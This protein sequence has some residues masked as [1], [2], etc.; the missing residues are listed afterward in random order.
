MLKLKKPRALHPRNRFSKLAK[1]KKDIS[2]VK[3]V[4]KKEREKLSEDP[5]TFFEQVVGFKPTVYQR[6]LAEKFMENQFT[7]MRWNRQSG[8]S[9]ISSALL[10]NYALTHPGAYIGIIAPGWRQSKLVIR[11]IRYFL[12][13]LPNEICPKPQ[14]TVLY[15]SNGSIIEAFP[16]NP[17][18]IRGPTLNLIYW[19]EANHTPN[20]WDM[21]TAILFTISATKGKVLVSSTP[22]NTDSIFYK[23]FNSE[24][25]SDFARSHVTWRESMEPNGPLD[26]GTLEKIRKQFSEDPWRWKREMEAEWAEDETAWLSQSLITKCIATEKTIGEELE[27]WDFER[28]HKGCNLYAGLD[29]GRVKD[30]SA[31]AVIE[32]VKRKFFLRHLKIFPLNT[33]YASVIGYIKTLQDRWGG[34][35][36]I[37][38]DSTN[39]DYV[40]EDMKNSDIDN[41]EGVHFTLPRKQEMATLFKQRMINNQFW[42]PYF[43]WERPY[44]GEFVTE[45]NVERFELR[46]DG[47]IAFN[48]PQGT[49]DDVWW[50][51]A[52]SL[53]ATV[54]MTAEPG[55]FIF[56]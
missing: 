46:K 47:S 32:E 52:L 53:Y 49:H 15:F 19:D 48:H 10:L 17:E 28:I 2:E 45:L 4:V 7:A 14:R 8:K 30:Y 9:W 16:N 31:L 11:R 55:P 37:R 40:V 38:V 34:F 18:T 24:E 27:L 41:V 13:K 36:K 51:V 43:T 42:Y 25:F 22:W 23:I 20:D 3:E 21:Y 33:S 26:K 39:Q 29:L 12:R 44:R 5:I 35:C 56:L 50:A 54:E 1:A 6:D